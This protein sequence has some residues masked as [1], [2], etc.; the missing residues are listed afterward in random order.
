MNDSNHGT[1]NEDGDGTEV[2]ESYANKA[3]TEAANM[4]VDYFYGIGADSDF[5]YNP[6]YQDKP[7]SV[8]YMEKLVNNVNAPNKD[9]FPAGDA[10]S[11]SNAFNDIIGSITT[12]Y[13]DV[14]IT[15]TLSEYVDFVLGSNGH[16]QFTIKV[17]D[18]DGNNVTDAEKTAGGLSVGYDKTNAPKKFSL[19]FNDD[20]TL[21]DGYTYTI[22]AIIEPN[23][24]AKDYYAEHGQYPD[25]M[26]GMTN[27]GTHS[28][29]EGFWSNA[30]GQATVTY[31]HSSWEDEL[32]AEYDKP[33]VQVP[34]A[35]LTIDKN[36]A[37][38][39]AG[40]SS[41]ATYTFEI[42]GPNTMNGTYDGVIFTNGKATVTITGDDEKVIDSLPMASYT[43]TET[44]TDELEDI[45]TDDGKAYYFAGVQYGNN[46]QASNATANLSTG[47]TTVTITNTYKPYRT[48][49]ITKNVTGEMGDTTKQFTFNTTIKRGEND[50][51]HVNGETIK[52]GSE[53]VNAELKEKNNFVTD[54][55]TLANGEYITISKLKD[56]DILTIAESGANQNGYETSYT[57]NGDTSQN[58]TV[59]ISAELADA[60]VDE[61]GEPDNIVKVVVT[62]TRKVVT[63]TGLES[64]HTKPYA[65]MVGAGALAGLALVGGILARRARRRR[66]W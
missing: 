62:N 11:L 36:V 2:K 19:E 14:T 27:T 25:G 43:V 55:Y 63:P 65:L 15:D 66:E 7:S 54:G 16:P 39:P 13:Y 38:L 6:D 50:A 1:T 42:Q 23:Q 37:G 59:T 53:T 28:E 20:Y 31:K 49:T 26:E 21:K 56:G 35:M 57:V 52:I 34:S 29:K 61:N 60:A 48:V 9:W 41:N 12:G 46:S 64:N 18:A 32:S 8:K 51:V 33:V 30:E 45:T 4:H 3:A 47:D 17:T 10:Q 22:S 24:T 44:G 40:T 58:D 5:N